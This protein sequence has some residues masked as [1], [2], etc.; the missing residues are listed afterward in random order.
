MKIT[1][2]ID[3]TS[4]S[5]S[6]QTSPS[7]TSAPQA[8]TY[9]PSNV[10]ATPEIPVPS[11]RTQDA[12]LPFAE[13][14][15]PKTT[16]STSCEEAWLQLASKAIPLDVPGYPLEPLRM[17]PQEWHLCQRLVLE[18]MNQWEHPEAGASAPPPPRAPDGSSSCP[19]PS[20]EDFRYKA[21]IEALFAFLR[22]LR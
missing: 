6:A 10:S 15:P 1:I 17:S 20:P 11:P 16:A 19:E 18:A 2:T 13:G 7:S 5:A 21:N 3:L 4:A 9:R 22:S 12:P 14:I 8:A